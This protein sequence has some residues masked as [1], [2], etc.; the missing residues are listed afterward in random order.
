MKVIITHY[1]DVIGLTASFIMLHSQT[2][3]PTE[4]IIIDTSLNKTGLEVISRYNYNLLPV[5]VI[6]K[7]VNINKAWNIGIKEAGEVD[8]L[9]I[10]DDLVIPNDLIERLQFCF[11]KSNAYCV[12][13]KTVD[14]TFSSNCI[15]MEY[16]PIS[17]GSP[18]FSKVEWMPGFCFA[19]SKDCIKDVG[20]ID[21]NF[22]IWFGDTDY[23][24]RIIET[25]KKNKRISI[26]RENNT[27]VYHFGGKSY[28]YQNSDVQ[29]K[30]DKD[31]SYFL[32]K[33]SDGFF[34]RGLKVSK[35]L[36][37]NWK[38]KKIL[39]NNFKKTLIVK[40]L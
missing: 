16:K 19:L 10:N 17:F 4:I 21:E 26:V 9:I 36:L 30:I 28:K 12:V 32:N 31:R 5:K 2:I 3:L 6:C 22:L 29:K 13:P 18:I 25:A 7:Q 11:D 35:I 15:E 14:R 38:S 1:S 39:G 23:E 20:L 34:K 27:Y 24:R 33:Y 40:Y 8:V 37:M